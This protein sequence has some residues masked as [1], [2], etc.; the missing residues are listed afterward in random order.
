MPGAPRRP[1]LQAEQV[2]LR[3]ERE[4]LQGSGGHQST[5]VVV[6]VYP[7]PPAAVPMLRNS[8]GME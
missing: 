2:R 6:G 4:K 8:I 1:Q 7:Q 3:Q 5:Q